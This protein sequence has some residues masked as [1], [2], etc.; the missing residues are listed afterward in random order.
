[1]KIYN[2]NDCRYEIEGGEGR[3]LIKFLEGL[4]HEG[5]EM[6]KI[7]IVFLERLSM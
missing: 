2:D 3:G 6:K 7:M 4:L 5:T 1:M